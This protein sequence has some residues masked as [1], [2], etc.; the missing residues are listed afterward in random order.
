MADT[1]ASLIVKIGAD[2]SQYVDEMAKASRQLEQMGSKFERVGAVMSAAITLPIVGVGAAALNVAGELEQT[3]IA[4]SH[5]LGGAQNAKAYLQDLY[6]FA[7]TTP[8]QIKDVTTGAQALMAMGFEAKSVIPTL[9][10]LG[11][12]LSAVG[13]MGNMQQIILAFGEMKAKGVASMKEI[14][15]MVVD[16]VIP[17]VKYLAEGLGK[18]EGEIF[19]MLKKKAIDSTTAIQLIMKGMHEH[20]GGLMES[21]MSSFLGMWSNFKDQATLTLND[22]GQALLPMAKTMLDFGATALSVVKNMAAWFASLSQPIQV[23]IVGL[24]GLAA[25]IGPVMVAVGFMISAVGQILGLISALGGLA[26]V[27][28]PI[29][30]AIAAIAAAWAAWELGK[31]LYQF[32]PVKVA[33]DGLWTIIKNLGIIVVATVALAIQGFT[34]LGE[35]VWSIASKIGSAIWSVIGPAVT[36]IGTFLANVIRGIGDFI[37]WIAKVTGADEKFRQI[38]A[39]AS[40][41]AS[42]MTKASVGAYDHA[43]AQFDL[44]AMLK[45]TNKELLGLDAAA[46]KAEK[47]GRAITLTYRDAALQMVRLEEQAW[48]TAASFEIGMIREMQRMGDEGRKSIEIVLDWMGRISPALKGAIEDARELA[49]AYKFLGIQSAAELQTFA[50][51]AADAYSVLV[52]SGIA[53]AHDILAAWIKMEE[54]RISAARAAGDSI[55]ALDVQAIEDAKRTLDSLEGKSTSTVQSTAK[56]AKQSIQAVS[57]VI[58][59]LSRGIADAILHAKS[60]GAVFVKVADDIAQAII[61]QLIEG[62]L[63]KLM[64]KLGDV[65]TKLGGVWAKIGGVFGGGGSSAAGSASGSVGSAGGG[66]G[67][68]GGGASGGAGALGG[69]AG[70]FSIA[71]AVGS[72]VSAVSGIVGNFQMMGMNK[73]LDLI[74]ANT[75]FTQIAL[76]GPAGVID[77][78]NRYLPGLVGIEARLIG[79][80]EALFDPVARDLEGIYNRLGSGGG[81]TNLTFNGYGMMDPRAM[82][83]AVIAEMRLAGLKIG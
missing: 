69:L 18:T 80:R 48:H 32:A 21:Q 36:A 52:N 30:W 59:D 49:A 19:D 79:V 13:R 12:Q 68:I 55:H 66:I 34:K 29:G 22:I 38:A 64:A 1:L 53:S 82:A 35:L 16:G 27:L 4:F 81:G 24:L 42:A 17:A 33:L 7:A 71:G 70:A 63:T 28:T 25:A 58:T 39:G 23:T 54:A 31:W 51:H 57:T 44:G 76:I 43:K 46:G 41:M 67:A 8:F 14:R 47:S 83:E 72:V 20:T 26:A 78:L 6:S 15:Q 11:D 45:G 50:E 56:V 9:T 10:V 75:R 74:E 73:S 5:F 3:Q 62:A 61:R 65:L 37:Q 60:F 2:I 40:A 77:R